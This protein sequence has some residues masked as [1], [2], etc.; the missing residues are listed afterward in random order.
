V[1]SDEVGHQ[2]AKALIAPSATR[3]RLTAECYLP[4]VE[5]EPVGAIEL[6]LKATLLAEPI[7]AGFA[8]PKRKGDLT[9]IRWPTCA[10]S[11][12]LPLRPG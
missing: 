10:I 8:R 2:V 11:L 4:L 7:E 3:D 12:W 1:P 6:A 9:T 5:N